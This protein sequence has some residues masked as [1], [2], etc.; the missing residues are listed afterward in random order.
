MYFFL[1]LL[2]YF[3][4]GVKDTFVVDSDRAFFSGRNSVLTCVGSDWGH[5]AEGQHWSVAY[6]WTGLG[7]TSW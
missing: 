4:N 6:H 7:L 3:K 2:P 5:V 1:P